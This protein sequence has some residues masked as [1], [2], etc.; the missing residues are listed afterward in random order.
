M[1]KVIT[2]MPGIIEPTSNDAPSAS[3]P[4]TDSATFGTRMAVLALI[5]PMTMLA[6]ARLRRGCSAN[7]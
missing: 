6:S 4:S 5:R 2:T 1:T 7:M 3:A